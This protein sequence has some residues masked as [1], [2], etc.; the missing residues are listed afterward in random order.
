MKTKAFVVVV[1]LVTLVSCATRIPQP[2]N[3]PPLLSPDSLGQE[4]FTRGQLTLSA[5]GHTIETEAVVE[6]SSQSMTV[7]ILGPTPRPWLQVKYT[8]DDIEVSEADEI[9]PYPL[10]PRRL[11]G[12]F[13]LALWPEISANDLDR[14]SVENRGSGED[15]RRRVIR[16]PDG[17][18]ARI[19][20]ELWPPWRGMMTIH[21]PDQR[22]QLTFEPVRSGG[23]SS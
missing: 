20:Y 13:Q 6:V 18:F 12:D 9:R 17:I 5:S 7:V 2:A 21:G 22:Y 1:L 11:I 4:L 14:F 10:A 3:T 19:N 15:Q 23:S 16:G 8:G